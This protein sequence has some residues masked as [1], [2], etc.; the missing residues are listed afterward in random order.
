MQWLSDSIMHAR[1]VAGGQTGATH[2]LTEAKQG[3]YHFTM[4]P[5][6]EPVLTVKPRASTS[7]LG[8]ATADTMTSSAV[9][10]DVVM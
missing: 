6:S 4:G 2:E 7:T 5:Y 1:G 10:A 8:S 3:K 9:T